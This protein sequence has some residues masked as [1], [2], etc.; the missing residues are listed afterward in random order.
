MSGQYTL[1]SGITIYP[2]QDR[3]I[4]DLLSR[5]SQKLPAQFLLLTDVTGQVI[6][7]QGEQKSVDLI[8]LGSLVAGDLAA[9]Q[10]IARLTGEYQDYQLVLREGSTSHTFIAEAGHYLALLAQVSHEVPL[11]WARV[12]LQKTAREL[13]NVLAASTAS[14]A[15]PPPEL[16]QDDLPDLFG[17]ALND[18]WKE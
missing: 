14:P 12:L 1:R 5:L 11:G 6:L 10:E 7:S 18:V 3:K 2:D 16:V 4:I 13:A 15:P 9:S 8:S 17:E